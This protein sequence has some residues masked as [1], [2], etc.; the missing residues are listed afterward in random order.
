LKMQGLGE[1]PQI[2]IF[3]RLSLNL[4]WTVFTMFLI[5][6]ANTWFFFP[7]ALVG[8]CVNNLLLLFH[9]FPITEVCFKPNN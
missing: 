4:W 9:I 8:F 3:L 2:G 5:L 6:N 7:L 1:I